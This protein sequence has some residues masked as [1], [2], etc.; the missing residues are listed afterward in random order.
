MAGKYRV[1]RVSDEQTINAQCKIPLSMYNEVIKQAETECVSASYYW[2]KW[3]YRGYRQDF[4]KQTIFKM[5][6]GNVPGRRHVL[7]SSLPTVQI[8]HNKKAGRWIKFTGFVAQL[9]DITL[10]SNSTLTQQQTKPTATI[11]QVVYRNTRKYQ[12]K[13][14]SCNYL[15]FSWVLVDWRDY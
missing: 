15:I 9:F 13:N 4:K 11:P 5:A 1:D 12:I 10:E 3:L 14:I 8:L 2:R 6:G 7:A